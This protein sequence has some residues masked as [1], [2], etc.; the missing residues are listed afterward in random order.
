MK[1]Q[2]KSLHYNLTP[3]LNKAT[4]VLPSVV[5]VNSNTVTLTNVCIH[6]L[7]ARTRQTFSHVSMKSMDKHLVF[8]SEQPSAVKR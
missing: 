6:S 8:Q 2:L 3:T 4:K 5:S 7:E 1:R